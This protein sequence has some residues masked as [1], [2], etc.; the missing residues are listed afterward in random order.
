MKTNIRVFFLLIIFSVISISNIFSNSFIVVTP[1][2]D[3]IC[4]NKSVINTYAENVT[5]Q[6]GNNVEVTFSV[7]DFED[8]ASISLTLKYDNSI[9]NYLSTEYIH[10]EIN[11]GTFNIHENSDGDL[12]VA[13]YS[14][15]PVNIGDDDLLKVLFS[16]EGGYTEIQ[17]D[18]LTTG[19]CVYTDLGFNELPAIFHNGSV[20]VQDGLEISGRITDDISG[21]G[22]EDVEIAFTQLG[23]VHTDQ[24]GNYL[25]S[26]PMNWSGTSEP[27]KLYYSFEPENRSYSNVNINYEDQNFTGTYTPQFFNISGKIIE[28]ETSIGIEGIKVTFTG[29]I[30]VFTDQNGD[31]VQQVP[32]GWSGFCEPQSDL[33]IFQPQQIEYINVTEDMQDQDF[34]GQLSFSISGIITDNSSGIGIEG[35]EINFSGLETVLTNSYGE[36]IIYVP[37]GWNGTAT[38]A[39]Y[40]YTF[41]PLKRDYNNVNSNLE[42]ED[43]I[44]TMTSQHYIISGTILDNQSMGIENVRINFSNIGNVFTDL[45]GDYSQ[46]VASGWSGEA[47]PGF[48]GYIFEPETMYYENVTEDLSGQDYIGISTIIISGFIEDIYTGD[49]IEGVNVNFT[50]FGAAQTNDQGFY[51]MELVQGWSG[52]AIPTK[53]GYTFEPESRTYVNVTMNTINQDYTGTLIDLTL[54]VSADPQEICQGYPT[55][56]NA[57]ASGGSGNY[58]Y[59]W[60]SS[61][62][63]FYSNEAS[64]IVYPDT[65]TIYIV[66]VDDGESTLNDAVNVIVN[67]YPGAAYKI[68]GAD[69]IC[70][71]ESQIEY[72]VDPIQNASEY[73]WIV[74]SG[75]S[76]QSGN[77]TNSI[78]VYFSETSASG[79]ISVRGINQCGIGLEISK[80]ITVNPLPDVSLDTFGNVYVQLESY[81]LS[82]GHP[83]GGVYTGNF[84]IGNYFYPQ[85]AGLGPHIITYSY[86]DP[87]NFCVNTASQILIVT[88]SPGIHE[89]INNL[90]TIRIFPNPSQG[91][92]NFELP[93]DIKNIDIS[94]FSMHGQMVFNSTINK[95]NSENLIHKIDMSFLQRGIYLIKIS[96]NNIIRTE[97]LL[98]K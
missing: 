24:D 87:E 10:D 64:P 84:V 44:G 78:S 85:S 5:A 47:T 14:L 66:V 60:M 75:V 29:L 33:Y 82:G 51:S 65:S 62:A 81:L 83:D 3:T 89:N 43:Y 27:Q 8:V 22:I 25:Q 63:G 7:T 37:N 86:T 54:S 92:I 46:N 40:G 96:N 68:F 28:S 49:G 79:L 39:K 21:E 12:K 23:S 55:Q 9:L 90:E 74:P 72:Y 91:I 2:H 32:Y 34:I 11:T 80:E 95:I 58:T 52:N 45:N 41:Y 50:G 97:K 6:P 26:V 20:S 38:P 71:E 15:N 17:W 59:S 53:I 4:D 88:N 56:L 69:T 48:M 18:T 1:M 70:I 31:F 16:Y 67:Y 35:V 76:I 94:V 36:Y 98:L 13:W 77:G 93:V 42:N 57:I 73:L 19:A 61:P 30:D